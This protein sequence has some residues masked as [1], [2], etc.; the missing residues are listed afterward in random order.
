MVITYWTSLPG[1]MAHTFLTGHNLGNASVCQAV[2][3]SIDSRAISNSVTKQTLYLILLLLILQGVILKQ[4]DTL[5]E[6]SKPIFSA[7]RKYEITKDLSKTPPQYKFSL[8]LPKV[9]PER[10]YLHTCQDLSTLDSADLLQ[11]L[12]ST[13]VMK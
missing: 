1:N 10:L 6:K 12:L 5:T 8:Q 7:V 2:C 11:L 9:F 13:S 4:N 3:Y